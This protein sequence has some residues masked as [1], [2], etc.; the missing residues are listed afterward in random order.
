MELSPNNK[1]PLKIVNMG[2]NG[3][4]NSLQC[5]H[6]PLVMSEMI[7]QLE[8]LNHLTE[9]REKVVAEQVSWMRAYIDRTMPIKSH[10]WILLG[11][12]SILASFAA[13]IQY[14]QKLTP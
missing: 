3:T 8:R 10:F 11:S 7:K 12:L 14:I 4:S 13:V 9:E 2:N 5:L 6:D 1:H